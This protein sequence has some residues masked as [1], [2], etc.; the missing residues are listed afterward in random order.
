MRALGM[1]SRLLERCV[2]LGQR[3]VSR[4]LAI[5]CLA[6]SFEGRRVDRLW[7]DGKGDARFLVEGRR[8]AEKTLS[9]KWSA[10]TCAIR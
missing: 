4:Q 9:A 2:A 8:P 3:A 1:A 7:R 10:F 5:E 6:R